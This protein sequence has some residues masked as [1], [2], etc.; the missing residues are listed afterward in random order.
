MESNNIKNNYVS[1]Y[2]LLALHAYGQPQLF[3]P[4]LYVLT[5]EFHFDFMV[6][7]K[8]MGQISYSF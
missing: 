8:E 5:S 7:L 3:P 2:S 6:F 4:Y 1:V